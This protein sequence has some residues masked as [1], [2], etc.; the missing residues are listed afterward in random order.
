MTTRLSTRLYKVNINEWTGAL[1]CE[2]WLTLLTVNA[3]KK[4]A[5]LQ[6]RERERERESERESSGKTDYTE[7]RR[8][9]RFTESKVYKFLIFKWV[10]LHLDGGLQV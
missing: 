2:N 10:S 3:Q 7:I 8:V 6:E 1:F 9:G 5:G 4:C